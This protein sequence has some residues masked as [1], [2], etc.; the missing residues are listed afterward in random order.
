M[1]L[2]LVFLVSTYICAA[3]AIFIHAQVTIG[4]AQPPSEGTLLDLKDGSDSRGLLLPRVLLSDIEELYPMF[5]DKNGVET[6][7]YKSDK[8]NVKQLH[9]GLI[10]FNMAEENVFCQNVYLWNGSAWTPLIRKNYQMVK[11]VDGNYYPTRTFGKAGTWMLQNLR[12][13]K[14]ADGTSLSSGFVSNA[15]QKYYKSLQNNKPEY[16]LL[17]SWAAAT[18]GKTG[19]N[20][21][22]YTGA[23]ADH[24]PVQGICPA[25]WRLP[26]DK[27]WQLLLEEVAA[28]PELYTTLSSLNISEVGLGLKSEIKVPDGTPTIEGKSFPICRGAGF[29]AL[30]V[31]H[32]NTGVFYNY[33]AT[34]SLWTS[35][36]SSSGNGYY[37]RAYNTSNNI[38]RGS[39]ATNAFMN[40][41][42][43]MK[44]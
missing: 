16:G 5:L 30:L 17:Y 4:S 1:K 27:D 26:R 36:L 6:E 34:T 2:R 24:T 37:L 39:G 13:T 14:Y 41:V 44:D 21:E 28:S 31:G 7:E 43:C 32:V 11:D 10:V 3:F 25:G 22:S 15:T 35:S 18:N 42:R 8:L 12:V 40:A 20:D 9:E 38:Y 23:H 19:S 29:N 33:G